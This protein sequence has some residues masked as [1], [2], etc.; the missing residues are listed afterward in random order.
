MHIDENKKFDKRNID[1]NMKEGIFTPKDYEI[2]LSRLPDV[3]DKAFV[4][5][6]LESDSTEITSKEDDARP[7]KTEPKKKS[8]RKGK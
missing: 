8:K 5:E 6:E 2:Y 3:I 4:D 1:K 7:K